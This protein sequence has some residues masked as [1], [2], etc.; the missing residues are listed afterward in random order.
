M[1]GTN[2]DLHCFCYI[3]IFLCCSEFSKCMIAAERKA[4]MYPTEII[5]VEF[6]KII[7]KNL[8]SLRFFETCHG[9]MTFKCG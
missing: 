7:P 6:F 3:R 5:T 9:F 8:S 2:V 4:L 1:K